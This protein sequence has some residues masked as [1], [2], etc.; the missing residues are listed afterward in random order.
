[1]RIKIRNKTVIYIPKHLSIKRTAKRFTE[2]LSFAI[3]KRDVKQFRFAFWYLFRRLRAAYVV[4]EA[5]RKNLYDAA[6]HLTGEL[7]L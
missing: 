6:E 2:E 4:S 3:V 5:E 1:M 7:K